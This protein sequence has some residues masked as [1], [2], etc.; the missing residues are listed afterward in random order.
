MPIVF[1][2]GVAQRNQKQFGEG[3]EVFLREYVAPRL[4]AA[5]PE[6]VAVLNAYWGR[7]GAAYAWD[8]LA[9]PAP[10]A[11]QMGAADNDL[12][13]AASIAD[14]PTMVKAG[15]A[16]AAIVA[17]VLLSTAP[18]AAIDPLYSL[19]PEVAARI[20]EKD[21]SQ[22]DAA[23][24]SLTA[25]SQGVILDQISD[26]IQEGVDRFKGSPGMLLSRVLTLARG[27]I[28]ASVTR[29]LGDIFVYLNGR[30]KGRS[31]TEEQRGDT[32]G[33]PG[34]IP[35]AVLDVLWDAA[36]TAPNEPLI[37]LSHSMGGQLMYDIVTYF[38]PNLKKS[39]PGK[40]DRV[41]VSFWGAAAC[42]VGLFEEM[43]LFKISSD[44]YSAA[45]HN[46]VPGPAED[47]VG[48]WWSVWDPNDFLSYRTQGI[49]ERVD[50]F[51]FNGGA[52]VLAAHGAY[53]VRPSFYKKLAGLVDQH[54]GDHAAN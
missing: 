32:E 23:G 50:D 9:V 19:T 30:T 41:K 27:P 48:Y 26:A 52:S 46:K 43:K 18:T 42:Q 15:D 45:Q 40:W 51:M 29:F 24:E 1:V 22:T 44:K 6:S 39:N 35:Q 11:R 3:V 53:L 31:M 14:V 12:Q 17:D 10:F 2:H 5:N 28:N 34:A 54:C 49:F 37:V 21:E 7:L 47:L 16:E 13:I 25:V 33:E 36:N 20:I 8:G 4:N 38:L